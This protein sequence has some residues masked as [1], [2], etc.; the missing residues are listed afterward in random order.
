M[1]K[2]FG[3]TLKEL[4]KEKKY[5]QQ[6]LADK[7]FVDRSSV[8]NWETGRR[9]P[10]AIFI[11]RLCKCLD[12][13]PNLLLGMAGTRSDSINILVVDD[14]EIILKGDIGV[15]HKAMPSA[16]VAGFSNAA[17]AIAYAKKYPINIAFLDL[18]LIGTDGFELCK[19][20]LS[21]NTMTNVI[22]LTAHVE[23]SY[24]AWDTGASG[25][26]IKPL[27]VDGVM[28]QMTKLRHP[29]SSPSH[30]ALEK[31]A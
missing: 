9:I 27:T 3:E 14:E 24:E 7:I 16:N 30:T 12:A 10:D 18:H 13:D 4:R 15:L 6:E 17:D 26:M 5:T 8:A 11:S 29:L 21:I 25:F 22:F 23:Y 19:K 1:Y 31:N 2:A 28:H 20:L